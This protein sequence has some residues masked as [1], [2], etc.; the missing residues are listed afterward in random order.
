MFKGR[1]AQNSA[2]SR[3][4][5]RAGHL[6]GPLCLL[7]HTSRT[8][9]HHHPPPPADKDRI[10]TTGEVGWSGVNHIR[11]EIGATKDYSRVIEAALVS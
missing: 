8:S 9:S 10:F 4:A 2:R 3:A 6:S 11:G 7:L 1:G 5:A